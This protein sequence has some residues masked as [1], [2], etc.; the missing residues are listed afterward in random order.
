[1][2]EKRDKAEAK[3]QADKGRTNS[4]ERIGRLGLNKRDL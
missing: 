2:K 1:V 4:I 3:R